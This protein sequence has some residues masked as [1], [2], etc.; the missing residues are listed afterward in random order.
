MEPS[1][2]QELG[3]FEETADLSSVPAGL[4][5]LSSSQTTFL[6]EQS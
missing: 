1:T 3:D 6:A 4:P 5:I 2:E